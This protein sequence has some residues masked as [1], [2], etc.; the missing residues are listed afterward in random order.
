MNERPPAQPE[1]TFNAVLGD[2]REHRRQGRRAE[3]LQTYERAAAMARSAGDVQGLA[4]ALRHVS[5]LA[6][7]LGRLPEALAAGQEAVG[8]LKAV[9]GGRRLDVANALRVTA[10]ALDALG[11]ADD[12]RTCWQ[13]ALAG[14][15]QAGVE[16]GVAECEARLAR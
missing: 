16:A 9:D 8:L 5:D 2:A 4:H 13:E 3:A 12:A 6:R 14:Y 15:A 1:P 11:R 7:E 10:L